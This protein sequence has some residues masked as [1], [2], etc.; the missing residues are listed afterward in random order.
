MPFNTLTP[1]ICK[2]LNTLTTWNR[3]SLSASIYTYVTKSAPEG[4]ALQVHRWHRPS[5][6]QQRC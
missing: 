1:W 6:W 4:A 2:S 3:D 5:P